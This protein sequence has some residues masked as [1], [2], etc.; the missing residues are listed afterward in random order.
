MGRFIFPVF[1]LLSLANGSLS[2]NIVVSS[3]AGLAISQCGTVTFRWIG[4]QAPYTIVTTILSPIDTAGTKILGTG[5]TLSSYSVLVDVPAGTTAYFTVSDS[6]GDAAGSSDAFTVL[7]S[8]DSSCLTT[9][10]TTANPTSNTRP[11]LNPAPTTPVDATQSSTNVGA[12]AGG[13]AGGAVVVLL[14]GL[15]WWKVKRRNG[16]GKTQTTTAGPSVLQGAGPKETAVTSKVA[17]PMQHADTNE[18]KFQPSV[19]V[20]GH[21]IATPISPVPRGQEGQ[22]SV[23]E[24][25]YN[26]QTPSETMVTT[27]PTSDQFSQKFEFHPQ[28]EHQGRTITTIT[29][30]QPKFPSCQLIQSNVSRPSFFRFQD[31]H[32]LG[33]ADKRARLYFRYRRQLCFDECTRRRLTAG[34][35]R[36]QELEQR[37]RTLETRITSIDAPPSYEH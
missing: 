35:S 14:I 36:E 6:V 20:Y 7:S 13:A 2:L 30:G 29:P 16:R 27:N 8:T 26:G 23:Q 25:V 18:E 11:T 21:K 32:E 24:L 12:I 34:P 4:G 3:L 9:L 19:E 22:A 28:V 5:V 33:P 17:P 31:H 10:P 1:G 37:L 15:C